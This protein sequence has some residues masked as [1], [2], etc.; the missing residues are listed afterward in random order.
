IFGPVTDPPR[1]GTSHRQLIM[2][3]V[4]D[5]KSAS[6]LAAL[7][8]LFLEDAQLPAPARRL[9]L[10][11][12]KMQPDKAEWNQLIE[13]CQDA[14]N[15]R[16]EVSQ[17]EFDP[18]EAQST[19]IRPNKPREISELKELMMESIRL[20]PELIGEQD[21]DVSK[22]SRMPRIDEVL[23][24]S[25]GSDGPVW[26]EALNQLLLALQQESYSEI[27]DLLEENDKEE[28][29]GNDPAFSLLYL[30]AGLAM[31]RVSR[32]NEAAQFYQQA[33]KHLPSASAL[34][35][36]QASTY[37]ELWMLDEAASLYEA[38]IKEIP[39]HHAAWH[40]LSMVYQGLDDHVKAEEAAE[41]A[42]SL[43]PDELFYQRNYAAVLF[44]NGKTFE[45]ADLLAAQVDFH[46]EDTDLLLHYALVL[47]QMSNFQTAQ[48]LLEK[49]M[50]IM[51]KD[52]EGIAYLAMCFAYQSQSGSAYD[53]VCD[54]EPNEDNLSLV[55][56]AWEKTA[57]ALEKDSR[58]ERAMSLLEKTL[59]HDEANAGAWLR[60]GLILKRQG[61]TDQALKAFEQVNTHAPFLARAWAE[62]AMIF[63]SRGDYINAADKFQRAADLDSAVVEWAFN[64]A[65]TWE[66]LEN[67]DKAQEAYRRAISLDPDHMGAHTNLALIMIHRGEVKEA[68]TL[69]DQMVE[70]H[71]DSSSGWFALGCVCEQQEDMDAAVDAYRESL[72][73]NPEKKEARKNL[74]AIIDR[75]S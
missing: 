3:C 12:S 52:I 13:E 32:Q 34:V 31:H 10:H 14:N 7:A 15:S 65:V 53:L 50:E 58:Q 46:P 8:R 75:V 63:Y 41:K 49:R 1:L 64:A 16:I 73:L 59:Q 66:K 67:M 40:N 56:T 4:K 43:R 61:N 5:P 26:G 72:K 27:S 36:Y 37:H 33:L 68:R 25:E 19:L 30:I 17:A 57:F 45:A 55:T 28:H 35:F 39:D 6:N 70:R 54:L 69:M 20:S 60:K 9:A 2:D 22:S 62:S 38:V 44:K 51:G 23:P 48:R 11:A 29:G 24:E 42:T 74:D 21:L 47:Y 18:A 71:P